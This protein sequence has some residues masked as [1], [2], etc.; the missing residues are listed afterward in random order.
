MNEQFRYNFT[1]NEYIAIID[2]FFS[3][4][5]LLCLLP[6]P[7]PADPEKRKKLRLTLK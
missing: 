7:E 2:L 6:L 1:K 3:K 4:W 5:F